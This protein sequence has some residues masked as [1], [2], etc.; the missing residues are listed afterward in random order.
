M[1]FFFVLKKTHLL[2][3]RVFCFRITL[4][5]VLGFKEGCW[6]IKNKKLNH[7]I[8]I[9]LVYLSGV[10]LISTHLQDYSASQFGDLWDLT[11]LHSRKAHNSPQREWNDA[12]LEPAA[13]IKCQLEQHLGRQSWS[14][15]EKVGVPWQHYEPHWVHNRNAA[16]MW[17]LKGDLRERTS[18]WCGDDASFLDW[19]QRAG[20]IY[21]DVLLQFLWKRRRPNQWSLRCAGVSGGYFATQ[22]I[23][24]SSQLVC[25]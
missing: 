5:S 18:F 23:G 10:F 24:G 7:P 22:L 16:A 13:L 25:S 4:N 15:A 8:W 12:P 21:C 11:R 2:R 1:F 19:Q 3:L 20:V 17:H 6:N 9:H 14:V